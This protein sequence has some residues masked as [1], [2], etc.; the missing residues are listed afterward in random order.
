MLSS[1]LPWQ[2]HARRWAGRLLLIL[3]CSGLTPAPAQQLWRTTPTF[4]NGPKQ[5]LSA[6][7]DS[8]LFTIVAGGVLATRNQG[9]RWQLTLH[10]PRLFSLY[11]SRS[12]LLLAGGAGQVYLSADQ[13]LSWD[14]VALA[15][16]Y[17]VVEFVETT[18]GA[19]LAATGTLDFNLGYVGS[20]VFFSADQGR[21]WTARSSGLGA[22][23]CVSH[24]A[25]DRHGRLYLSVTDE[26]AWRQ[27]GLYTSDD[28]GLSWRHVP[29]RINGRNVIHDDIVAYE[30][31]SLTVSPHDTLLCSLE[32]SAV[33][34]GVRLNLKKALGDVHRN[35]FWQQFHTYSS[36]IWWLDQ[37]LNRIHF[38]RNGD[39]Y[40]SRTGSA[41]LGG[42]MV[43]RDQGRSWTLVQ[44]GLGLN[45]FGTRSA[46]HF[47]E[48]S[49][50]KIFMVQD[51]D[52]RVYATTASVLAANPAR[53]T[54]AFQIYP[55]P[56]T[57]TARLINQTGQPL[58]ALTLTDLSG[59]ELR[60][61]RFAT[62]ARDVAL[63]LSSEKAGVY[64]VQ[65]TLADGRIVRQRLVKR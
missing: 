40:S 19:L 25:A 35:T 4:P 33:N 37:P 59:R 63:N 47:A 7:G 13:G 26:E 2:T 27:P 64:L 1:L 28:Q 5:G 41:N 9:R 46:Q 51:M 57:S 3:C 18:T 52:E 21:S 53:P 50:G 11:T 16:P 43:S 62:P 20:G 44:A 48:T 55:N 34:V 58:L 29:L 17:P 6:T 23:H 54:A 31:T 8:T 14:S 12:G 15:S 36:A 42:T 10:S 22:G 38:A 49:T 60:T 61:L 24:L 32:G 30:F 39:W 65:A 56:T 45:Q